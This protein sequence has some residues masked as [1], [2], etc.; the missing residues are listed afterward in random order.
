MKTA[1]S[2]GLLVLLL[3]H[4]L[5]WSLAV[6]FAGKKG[7]MP[8]RREPS[9][10]HTSAWHRFAELS[11][12]MQEMQLAKSPPTPLGSVLKM[13]GGLAKTYL[14][15]AIFK[16]EWQEQYSFLRKSVRFAEPFQLPVPGVLSQA[17]P[18]PEMIG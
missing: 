18:P 1:A 16:S 8:E 14:P 13:L 9:Q 6:L 5:G 7:D 3:S 17:T 15:G 4:S 11:E 12:R 2:L 10:S